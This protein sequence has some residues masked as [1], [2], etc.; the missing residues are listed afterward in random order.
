M[1]VQVY[2]A[3]SRARRCESGYFREPSGGVC[4]RGANTSDSGVQA[5][6]VALFPRTRNFCPLCLFTPGSINWY[7]RHTAGGRGGTL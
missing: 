4:G 6:P 5:S 3:I 7:W 1:I 2:F